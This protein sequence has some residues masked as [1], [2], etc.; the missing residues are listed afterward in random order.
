MLDES[1]VNTTIKTLRLAAACV[2]C[3][4]VLGASPVSAERALGSPQAMAAGP[5]EDGEVTTHVVPGNQPPVVTDIPDQTIIEGTAFAIIA[6]DDHV[7]DPDHADSDLVWSYSG[8]SEL[9][10]TI[11]GRKA[12]ITPPSPTWTGSE[13][14][15]FTATDPGLL[16]DSD[17]AT[18]TVLPA[19]TPP[20]AVADAYTVDE[21][22]TLTV[23]A[24]GV[25]E[26]DSDAEDDPITATVVTEPAHGTLSFKADGSF[27]YGHDGSETTK[28]R[29]T[30]Y[31]SDG[32]K[33]SDVV[34]VTLTINPINDL[35][36]AVDDA[37]TVSEGATLEVQAPGVLDNDTDAEG[38]PLT[39]SA[40]T[41]PAHGTLTLNEDGSFSYAHDGSETTEDCFTYLVN[42]GTDD[43]MFPATVTIT[44]MAENDPPVAK[45]DVY[46]VERG[47]TLTVFAP[48]VLSNDT[49]TE[50]NTLHAILV[51]NPAHGTLTFNANGAFIYSHDGSEATS[52]SFTYKANDGLDDSEIATVKLTVFRTNGAPIANNDTAATDEGTAV[53]VD[54]LAND[55]D[56]ENDPLVVSRYDAATA[57]GG[58]VT[59][60]QA[61]ICTYTPP[62]RYNG[63]DSFSYTA[64]DNHGD[65]DDATVTVTVLPALP[66]ST[67][68]PKIYLPLAF[69]NFSLP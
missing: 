36:V 15:T 45:D 2:L 8:A 31:A 26:N 52:D 66:P 23:F 55:L 41:S 67:S 40:L 7:S 14:I 59:C 10:V 4:A 35:P 53:A 64:A 50:G 27:V 1:I 61:G 25:L 24:P 9:T 20:E 32:E 69:R 33:D 22:A 56:P 28:D 37:Y 43:A 5:A 58:Q 44:V 60:D 46:S 6:L 19:N 57:Q 48:G 18:F 3:I 34:T 11:T 49:D 21:G 38:D 51:S 63:P 29:F 47:A 39:A 68:M 62:E 65:Q 17:S 42:D 30:Y 54:V 16:C 13:A 12:T